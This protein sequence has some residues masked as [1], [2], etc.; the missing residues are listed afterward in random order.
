MTGEDRLV[1]ADPQKR[2]EFLQS[3]AALEQPDGKDESEIPFRGSVAHHR[4]VGVG[5]RILQRG[6]PGVHRVRGEGQRFF[7][8]TTKPLRRNEAWTRAMRC[9]P[10]RGPR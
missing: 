8:G 4:H 5:R 9:G 1:C 2:L 6:G 7:P 10:K 3:E